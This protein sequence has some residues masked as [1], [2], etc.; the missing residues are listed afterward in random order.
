M[1][2]DRLNAGWGVR[3]LSKAAVAYNP[4]DYQTGAIWPH[5]SAMVAVGL[6]SYGFDDDALEILT[7][8]YEAATEF[9]LYR[10]PELFAGFDRA[11]YGRPVRYP[12]ACSPQAWAAGSLPY[13]LVAV[14]GIVP[15]A[16][17][18]TMQVIRPRL[19]VWLDWVEVKGLAIG[20]GRVDL[21]FE[22]SGDLTLAA[23]TSKSDD[24]H[25]KI[26]Y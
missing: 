23:V 16:F 1:D 5:D 22:R 3:T 19:P 18:R 9:D 14:L 26:E 10:L 21:R 7:G 11:T 6:R 25:V 4:F 20:A 15:D 17:A 12:V 24:V 8:L 13:L 2:P